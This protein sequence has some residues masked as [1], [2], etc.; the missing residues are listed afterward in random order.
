[1]KKI[2]SDTAWNDYLY[3]Q[4]QDRRTLK[5]INELIKDIDRNGD[6]CTGKPEPLT[7]S[8][9]GFWSVR[10][11]QKIRLIFRILDEKLEIAQCRTHYGDN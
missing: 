7:G 5:K 9:A 10:I 2:W 3:W 1:M 6:E 8:F 11:D 4:T